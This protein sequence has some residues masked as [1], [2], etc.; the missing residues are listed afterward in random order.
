MGVRLN[1][2]VEQIREDMGPFFVSRLYLRGKIPTEDDAPD[3]PSA[4]RAL[5]LACLELGYDPERRK[6]VA[7]K[8]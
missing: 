2:L 3:D 8:K 1:E 6:R 5:V 4:V 7:N